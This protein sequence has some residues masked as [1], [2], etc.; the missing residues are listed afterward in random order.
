MLRSAARAPLPCRDLSQAAAL[1]DLA[2]PH[3]SPSSTR[4]EGFEARLFGMQAHDQSIASGRRMEGG[5]DPLE[6]PKSNPTDD[7]IAGPPRQY[8]RGRVDRM[9][10]HA[11]RIQV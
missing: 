9:E 2:L 1:I 4:Q 7:D 11:A 3:E 8:E 6:S 10:V 5:R